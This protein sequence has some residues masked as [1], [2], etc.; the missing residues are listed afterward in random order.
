[1]QHPDEVVVVTCGVSAVPV[2]V[3]VTV[4]TFVQYVEVMLHGS[5]THT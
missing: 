4:I 2:G 5:S 3:A 1:M